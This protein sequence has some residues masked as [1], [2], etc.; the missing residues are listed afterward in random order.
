MEL[1]FLWKPNRLAPVVHENL[2]FPLHE[3]NPKQ[4]AYTYVYA[5]IG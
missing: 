3:L 5:T 1:K 4:L 2:G